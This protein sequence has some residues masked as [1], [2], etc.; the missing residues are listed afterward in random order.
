MIL[1]SLQK[2]A[3]FVCLFLIAGLSGCK[4]SDSVPGNKQIQPIPVTI[5][6]LSGSSGPYN[7]VV[8]ITGTGFDVAAAND[9][10]SFNGKAAVVSSATSTKL[11]VTVPLGAGTGKVSVSVKG[12]SAVPG[13]VFTYQL[14]AFVSTLAGSGAKGSAN[15]L[16][17]AASFYGPKQIAIDNAGNLYVTDLYNYQIRK[18]DPAGNVTTFAGSINGGTENGI[19]SAARFYLPAAIR[20]DA[21]GNFYIADL[22]NV[23]IRK[24]TPTGTVSTVYGGLG[25]PT[26]DIIYYPTGVAVDASGNI[27]VSDSGNSL[28][29][30]IS[31]DGKTNTIVAGN[32]IGGF[33]DGTGTQVKFND[34]EGLAFKPNGQPQLLYIADANNNSIRQMNSVGTT[35]RFVGTGAVGA[36]NGPG[37]SATFNHPV[38]VNF[39]AS[40]NMYI[41][42]QGNNLIR[43]MDIN[44]KV[45]TLAGSG[46]KGSTDGPATQASFNAP[47]GVAIDAAGN[48]YV[49]D[50]GNNL[51][52]KISFQ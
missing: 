39:D 9:Q 37:S 12:A 50:E 19:G 47:S 34:P 13:P 46:A 18:I 21:A 31:P 23:M 20:R 44:G 4:K 17:T 7:T 45:T 30:R 15:G 32:R 27:Y 51:V 48:V 43:K 22:G 42:D 40:G 41:V 10:V 11:T 28:I 52:R 49:A 16:G 38:D 1:S 35:L 3:Y 36:A 33:S 25:V 5:T 8:E 29:R 24:I 14:T 26:A 2:Q 6:S